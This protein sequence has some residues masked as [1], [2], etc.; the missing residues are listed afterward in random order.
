MSKKS[1][2]ERV[3]P[4][5]P[6]SKLIPWPANPSVNVQVNV[7]GAA[8]LEAAHL[9]TIEHFRSRAG[10]DDDEKASPPPTPIDWVFIARERVAIVYRAFT[11]PD[12]GEKLA[13]N[14]DELAKQPGEVLARLHLEWSSFQQDVAAQP[15]D[16]LELRDLIEALKKNTRSVPLTDFSSSKLIVLCI[17]LASRLAAST[18]DNAGG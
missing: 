3:Q 13:A 9:E 5:A 12:T 6:R 15:L 11:D 16:E 2:V 1:F 10:G 8:D 14:V 7:L 18:K 17:G 4:N